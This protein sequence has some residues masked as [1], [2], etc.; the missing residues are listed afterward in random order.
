MT[1]L[2]RSTMRTGWHSFVIL[3]VSFVLGACSSTNPHVPFQGPGGPEQGP[4]ATELLTAIQ[5][6]SMEGGVAVPPMRMDAVMATVDERLEQAG[7][8]RMRSVRIRRGQ[9]QPP[10]ET[11]APYFHVPSED[12]N[13][14]SLPLKSTSAQVNIAGVISQ[15]LV[16][17]VYQNRGKTPIEAVYVFPG[18]TR[19]AV[20]GMRMTIGDRVIVAKIEEREKA[21]AEYEAA[22]DQGKRAS[23]LEQQRP[24]VFTMNVANIMPGDVIKTELLYSELLVPEEGVYSFVYPTVVGPRNPMGSDPKTVGWVANPHL[25]EGQKEPYGFDIK[26]HLA[27]PIDLKEVSSPSHPVNVAYASPKAANITL[28]QA[29]GGNRDYVLR[30]RLSGDQIESGVMVY[31]DGGERFF[32]MMMEPPRRVEQAQIPPREYVFVL[33]VSGSMRGFPLDVSKEL[34][35]DLLGKMRPNDYFNVVLF[36][37]R[38]GVLSERS[39]PATRQN[40]QQTLDAILNLKGGGGTNLMDAL[41]TSYAL[42][43]PESRPMSRSVVVVTDGYVSVEAKAFRFIRKRLGEAN[44]FSFGIGSSVNRALIEGMARAGMG[45]PFVVLDKAKAPEEAKKLRKYIESPLLTNI[46]VTFEGMDVYD[47]VPQALPD[48]MAARPLILFG[49]VRG[50]AR[51]T[52]RVVGARGTGQFEGRLEIDPAA[53]RPGNRPLRS[54]WA[55]KWAEQLMDQYNALGG[56]DGIKQAVT[57]LGLGYGLLTQFTSFVAIDSRVANTTGRVDTVRQP[58]PLPQGVSNSALPSQQKSSR[59]GGAMLSADAAAGAAPPPS[60]GRRYRRPAMPKPVSPR[61]EAE[62]IAPSPGTTPTEP[63]REDR[64]GRIRVG[65]MSN[66]KPAHQAAVRSRV[67]R[68]LAKCAAKT[69]LTGKVIVLLYA[70]GRA[71]IKGGSP[72]FRQCLQTGRTLQKLVAALPKGFLADSGRPAILEVTIR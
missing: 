40:V 35:K 7:N 8:S 54:L 59:M 68:A 11:A 69:G 46:Q 49:K 31:D 61:A 53:A 55:R 28:K 27:S 24:N 16:T 9:D 43:R 20:H 41:R 64:S 50:G 4:A 72:A 62:E 66:I 52:I 45:S 30:Y 36:A 33:D 13:A 32:L 17:Q 2:G 12:G 57:N 48:L 22:K 19:A 25:S 26:V 65:S 67:E 29:G 10:D 70:D 37:G 63:P 23:L 6:W 1:A 15:V 60:P 71:E 5:D 38:S 44:L 18:S 51:G 3:A 39:L 42:P 34:M 14:E 21:R 47:A 58:L 56:D